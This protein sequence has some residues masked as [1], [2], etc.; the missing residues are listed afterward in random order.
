VKK[1][2]RLNRRDKKLM[3]VCAGLSDMTGVDATIV[4]VALVLITL[5]GAFPWTV[6][7]YLLAGWLAKPAD[8]TSLDIPAARTRMSVR[9]YQESLTDT[10]RRMDEIDQYV[11]GSTDNNLAREIERLR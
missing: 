10:D 11:A 8:R 6:I 9:D 5:A 1:T 2:F 3:G 4:R 7:A